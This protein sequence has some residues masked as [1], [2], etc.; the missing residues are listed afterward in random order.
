[1]LDAAEHRSKRAP[2]DGR[3]LRRSM[4]ELVPES[5]VTF[6]KRLQSFPFIR[7]VRVACFDHASL[8]N[9]GGNVALVPIQRSLHAIAHPR[10]TTRRFL[11]DDIDRRVVR[12]KRLHLTKLLQYFRLLGRRVRATSVCF[13]LSVQRALALC[14]CMQLVTPF[15][16]TVGDSLERFEHLYRCV[17]I[18]LVHGRALFIQWV[19]GRRPVPH[20]RLA[21]R[22]ATWHR[23]L[24]V[25]PHLQ[26][27]A[28]PKL[29]RG[30][31]TVI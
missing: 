1:M 23:D 22:G 27:L 17:F 8:Y 30:L 26:A 25:Q 11:L 20:A 6:M 19:H 12:I 7:Q 29:R 13:Q 9:I 2:Y 3:G 14:E 10:Q 31:Q 4:L 28:F 24:V 15:L 16:G 5:L 21:A 18:A